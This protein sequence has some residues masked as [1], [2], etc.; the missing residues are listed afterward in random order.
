MTQR[1]I[2]SVPLKNATSVDD[3]Y[4][5]FYGTSVNQKTIPV[6]KRLFI[7]EDID[8]AGMERVVQRRRPEEVP[9]PPRPRPKGLDRD[10]CD[11]DEMDS[12]EY[13]A[14]LMAREHGRRQA[15]KKTQDESKRTITMAELLEVFDGVIEMKGVSRSEE[16]FCWL[17]IIEMNYIIIELLAY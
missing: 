16:R 17:G 4:K 8:C 3:L 14:F 2:V 9:P 1:H 12:G 6:H 7:L 11:W 15:R 5:V 10:E 13:E